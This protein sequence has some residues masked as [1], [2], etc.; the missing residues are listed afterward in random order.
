LPEARI[1]I[2]LSTLGLG[3]INGMRVAPAGEECGW[4]IWCGVAW[5]DDPNFFSTLCVEHL[6]RR[7]PEA[8]EYLDLPPGYRFLI[9]GENF[10]DVWFDHALLSPVA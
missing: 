7:L 3:P 8:V 1:G 9:D 10:E 4:Y 2:A 5:S 6:C